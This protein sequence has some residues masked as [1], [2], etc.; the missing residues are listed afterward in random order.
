MCTWGVL[1]TSLG[2]ELNGIL[3]VLFRHTKQ[4]FGTGFNQKL[5]HLRHNTTICYTLTSLFCSAGCKHGNSTLNTCLG[6]QLGAQPS[7]DISNRQASK[8]LQLMARG[9]ENKVSPVPKRKLAE[10]VGGAG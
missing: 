2:Y 9:E 4:N 5:L 10:W 3:S 6:F 8:L 7:Q 1:S